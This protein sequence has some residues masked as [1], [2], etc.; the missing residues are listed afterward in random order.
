MSRY[1]NRIRGNSK[2]LGIFHVTYSTLLDFIDTFCKKKA[3]DYLFNSGVYIMCALDAR[4]VTERTD[5]W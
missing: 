4:N 3:R 1:L 5:K 2:L